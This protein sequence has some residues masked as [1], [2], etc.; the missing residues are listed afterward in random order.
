MKQIVLALIF[1]SACLGSVAADA[2]ASQQSPQKVAAQVIA[3]FNAHRP[4]QIKSKAA[5]DRAI[6]EK[7][8]KDF[9]NDAH[10]FL[11]LA[12]CSITQNDKVGY[13]KNLEK[14]HALAPKDAP[15]ELSYVVA[16]KMNKQ[17]LKALGLLKELAGEYPNIAPVQYQ[18][19]QM[20]I[21]VQKYDD[22][23]AIM[24]P[25]LQKSPPILSDQDQ[26]FYL[27]FL[28]KCY[29]YKGERDKAIDSL[30]HAVALTPLL[31]V[32]FCVLGE[33]Y[34]KNDDPG[35]AGPALDQALALNPRSPAALYYKG[36]VLEKSGKAD[37]AHASYQSA[38]ANLKSQL[39]ANGE[40]GEDYYLMFLICQKLSRSD[41]AAK[42]KAEAAT[43]L[44]TFEAPWKQK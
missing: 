19:A 38:Y 17:P 16:L 41:E 21:I 23:I 13:L 20:D 15:I 3:S 1:S 24:E 25:I 22:A 44:Y 32:A 10:I 14:A 11:A 18:L 34:L 9:P 29:L 2:P 5:A 33:A 35:E 40:N 26:S 28:G 36:I 30:K 42:N 27:Y 8:A 12:Y 6:L 37:L 31:D 43:L 4:A 39:D 7:G